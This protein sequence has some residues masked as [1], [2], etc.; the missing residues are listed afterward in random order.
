M[1]PRDDDEEFQKPTT[2]T[3]T[4]S[5]GSGSPPAADE[6]AYYV[7][8]AEDFKVPQ[9]PRFARMTAL[10]LGWMALAAIG[11]GIYFFMHHK[12]YKLTKGGAEQHE[13]FQGIVSLEAMIQHA[14][15][16]D[17]WVGLHGQVYDL[18][19]YAPIHPGESSLITRHCGT[20]ATQW[21]DFE[22]SLAL[23]PIVDPY[24]LGT[25]ALRDE[26]TEELVEEEEEVA[27]TMEE[28][29]EALTMEEEEALMVEEASMVT[30]STMTTGMPTV[31][32]TLSPSDSPTL[33]PT[34]NPTVSPTASPSAAPSRAPTTP[35]P[36]PTGTFEPTW[37]P[38][39]TPTVQPTT[40][41][42]TTGTPTSAPTWQPT[43]TPTTEAPTMG[44]ACAMEF[45][46]TADLAQHADEDSCWYGLYGVVYDLTWYIDDHKG[47]RG[48]ILME[49]GTD[50]TVPFE[51][52]KKHDVDLLI[53]KGF[54]S[55]IIGRLGSTR[56]RQNVPCD[57]V[58][59]VA[60]TV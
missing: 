54:A 20:D 30:E 4:S 52:E 16:E 39:G 59:A 23:L 6:E 47:G 13:N 25:L 37:E 58:D 53:K 2:T 15:P 60:V 12:E 19:E 43:D 8:D 32:P 41:E 11:V 55:S 26:T 28:G 33:S 40:L 7:E 57:E 9:R 42:P 49:C 56:G 51:N 50:A 36:T 34:K 1:S 22:H 35:N 46:T 24:L 27:V 44:A 10:L 14:D 29:E 45:Y 18:T 31:H 21:Y 3:T 48:T 5:S 38:T 17:C